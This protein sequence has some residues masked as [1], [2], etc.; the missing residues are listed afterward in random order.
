MSDAHWME[1][2]FANAHGQLHKALGVPKGKTIPAKKLASAANSSN[3]TMAKR[4][5]LARTA[6][7]INKK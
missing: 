1:K 3:T 7:N 4:A 2:A 6:R 5:V